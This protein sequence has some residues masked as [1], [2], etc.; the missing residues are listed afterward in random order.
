MDASGETPG[1]SGH[2]K[3]INM[4]IYTVVDRL[5]KTTFFVFIKQES[6]DNQDLLAFQAEMDRRERKEIKVSRVSRESRE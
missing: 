4:V 1:K 5:K 3:C 2:K 6:K